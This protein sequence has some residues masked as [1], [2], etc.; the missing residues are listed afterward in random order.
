[1]S[2]NGFDEE[3]TDVAKSWLEEREA[4]VDVGGKSCEVITIRNQVYQGTVWGHIF[5]NLHFGGVREP[6][7][8]EQGFTEIIYVDEFNA[9]KILDPVNTREVAIAD[10]EQC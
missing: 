6:P 10:M 2:A 7:V 8:N 3:F 4:T 9:I 5:W 1:M